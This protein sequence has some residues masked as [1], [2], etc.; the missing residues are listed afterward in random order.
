VLVQSDP[1]I[2]ALSPVRQLGDDDDWRWRRVS[3]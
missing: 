3:Y 1:M 2:I